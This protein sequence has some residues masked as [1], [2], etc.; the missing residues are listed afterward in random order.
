MRREGNIIEEVVEYSNMT[1]AFDTVLHGTARKR[2][3]VGKYLMEHREE[4][5]E[6]LRKSI[7]NGIPEKI[8][9]HERI[10]VEGVKPRRI[11]VLSMRSRIMAS[12]V[13]NVVDKH[14]KKRFIRTTSASIKNRGMH[15]LLNYIQR[16]IYEDPDGTMYCYKFDLSKFYERVNQDFV[17]ECVHKMFKDKLLISILEKFVRLLPDGISIGLRSSQGLG[18]L[19]LSVYLDHYLKDELGVRH[20]YR[21]CDDGVVL[22][23]S[24]AELWMIRD[25]VHEKMESIGLIVKAN[26][27]VFPVNEG[28]D[29]LG[30][31]I[32]PDHVRL[33][34][35]IKQRMARKMHEVKSKRR[36]RELVASFYGMAKH[37]DS[38][39][40]FN[41]LTG[42]EMKSFK[43]LNVAYKPEDGKKRFS[44]AVVSI[45][46]LVN[47]PIVVKDFET[48]IKTEQ[49]EDR[50]IVSIDVN[51]EPKKFFTNSE[52]MKN[53]LAQVSE[54]DDGFPFET[55]I[56]T[57][58]FGKGRT[59]YV[60]S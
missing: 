44:G 46:E 59:K 3:R 29:F 48:G 9:Y 7:L 18:N 51:G 56:K 17:M 19:L 15:D 4:V 12:A 57:E 43:D 36:K 21:Y 37:A 1:E 58:T 26:E 42:K 31:V 24:K 16:D 28:I 33:R 47:L 5:I 23:K 8:D 50:C 2:S 14:L 34:K 32:Y 53:I 20:F 49:G 6:E 10:I 35:R 27:R 52:E 55:T 54:M 25:A 38:I 60:F 13:M 41:K 40:L 11:Q 30:Y 39:M 22:A 45:R